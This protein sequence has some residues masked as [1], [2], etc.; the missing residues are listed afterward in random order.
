MIYLGRV[1]DRVPIIPPF[2][3]DHHIS[4]LHLTCIYSE[5]TILQL[6]L[7]ALYHSDISSI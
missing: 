6:L 4:K 2:G 1:S 3:P 5:F 7:R